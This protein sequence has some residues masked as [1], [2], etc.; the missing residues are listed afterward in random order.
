MG[1]SGAYVPDI[2]ISVL[3]LSDRGRGCVGLDDWDMADLM[4]LR[5][6]I[7]VQTATIV[8]KIAIR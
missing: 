6:L 7:V 5:P 2:F 1:L 4:R 3:S 8:D